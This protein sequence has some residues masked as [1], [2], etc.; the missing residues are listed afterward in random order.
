MVSE[1]ENI[2]D[3]LDLE[4]AIKLGQRKAKEG[5]LTEA[6]DICQ[7]ITERFPHNKKAKELLKK[8]LAQ[9]AS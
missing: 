9:G 3:N 2:L 7:D 5:L 1:K 4:K 8:V 6:L